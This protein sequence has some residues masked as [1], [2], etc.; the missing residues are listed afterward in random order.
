MAGEI[1]VD[2]RLRG[3]KLKG[4]I[5]G[6]PA[7]SLSRT[8]GPVVIGVAVSVKDDFGEHHLSAFAQSRRDRLKGKRKGPQVRGGLNKI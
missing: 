4:F 1:A 8:A 7:H 2:L 5:V 3:E 6:M